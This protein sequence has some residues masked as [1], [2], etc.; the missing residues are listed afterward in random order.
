MSVEAT[1]G[2]KTFLLQSPHDFSWVGKLGIVEAVFDQQDSGNI[3]FG[4]R[5]ES[6]RLFVKYAGARGVNYHGSSADAIS[7][8]KSSTSVYRELR[9]DLLPNLIDSFSTSCG[10]AT[11]FEWV[12]GENLH[13]YWEFP[14][15]LKYTHPASPYHR[16]R[17]LPLSTRLRAFGDVLRFH[18]HVERKGYVAVDFYDGS[19][20]YDFA[21][22]TLRI[23][24]IDVYT[25]RPC[26]NEMGR[27]WGSSRFMSPEEFE[28]GA[29]IDERTNVF[30]MG[31]TAFCML[32]S[33]RDRS[34]VVWEG[35][36]AQYLIAKRAVAPARDD[37]YA[38]V[39]EL[40]DAWSK[41]L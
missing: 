25:R 16:F 1:I 39:R 5:S 22:N 37:R 15:P 18:V 30:A 26:R 28:E 9:H 12:D 6:G 23:C 3:C 2:S 41:S 40:A 8:L 19:I 32:G 11:V 33:D 24:D 34:Q 36:D 20:M 21:R 13:P 38:S 29:V 35:T 7:R 27:M 17:K 10:F 4:I 31:A 14:P